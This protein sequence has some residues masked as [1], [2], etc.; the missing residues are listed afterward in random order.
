MIPV[1]IKRYLKYLDEIV[2]CCTDIELYSSLKECANEVIEAFESVLTEEQI[3]NIRSVRSG[4]NK[5]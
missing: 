1:I 5:R 2:Y 3:E 4:N